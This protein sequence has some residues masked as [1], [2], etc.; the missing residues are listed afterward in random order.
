MSTHSL[1]A[2]YLVGTSQ[3]YHAEEA[4]FALSGV[5]ATGDPKFL[6]EHTFWRGALE[7]PGKF[8]CKGRENIRERVPRN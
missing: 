5:S 1:P 4:V 7:A 8:D 6:Q 3:S 2:A